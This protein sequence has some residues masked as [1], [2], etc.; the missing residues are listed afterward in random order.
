MGQ[1]ADRVIGKGPD[2]GGSVTLVIRVIL[3]EG[4]LPWLSLSVG[5]GGECWV[6]HTLTHSFTLSYSFT[7]MI[8]THSWMPAGREGRLEGV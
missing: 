1:Q 4:H 2:Q 5:G 6:T 7:H 3:P 8:H